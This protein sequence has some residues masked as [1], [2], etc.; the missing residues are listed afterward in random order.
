MSDFRNA[1]EQFIENVQLFGNPHI[2]PEKYNLYN[3][4]ANLAKGLEKLEKKMDT[5]E[6]R[7][8]NIEN[9]L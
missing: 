6:R 8:I 3:G 9:K 7:I 4:L 1:K 5:L 2:E